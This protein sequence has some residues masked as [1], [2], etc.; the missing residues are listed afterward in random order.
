MHSRVSQASKALR[1]LHVAA[2][3]IS[4]NRHATVFAFHRWH[5]PSKWGRI[6]IQDEALAGDW[7]IQYEILL[8]P[9][10]RGIHPAQNM[11]YANHRANQRPAQ[12]VKNAA[13]NPKQTT[14]ALLRQGACA[15]R[16]DTGSEHTAQGTKNLGCLGACARPV[17]SPGVKCCR[18][19]AEDPWRRVAHAP[20]PSSARCLNKKYES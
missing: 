4:G 19:L 15:T 7:P 5:T 13:R 2:C 10:L 12:S 11:A 20:W 17:I 8:C 6:K 18:C 3:T 1:C 16:S 14:S 9:H